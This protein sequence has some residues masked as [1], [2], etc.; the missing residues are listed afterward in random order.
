MEAFGAAAWSLS[1]LEWPS[2]ICD[3]TSSTSM[4]CWVSA[5]SIK[6]GVPKEGID[7]TVDRVSQSR[8]H[9]AL[10]DTIFA[11]ARTFKRF[12]MVFFVISVS[13]GRS[14]LEQSH[15]PTTYPWSLRYNY[16]NRLGCSDVLQWRTGGGR[17]RD[18][19]KSELWP[20]W[21]F[22]VTARGMG[23]LLLG[24]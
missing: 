9:Q 12:F 22:E 11:H 19:M 5:R 17:N 6:H 2:D 8:F 16:N 3:S 4:M 23:I 24:M 13:P 14:R 20:S 10:D 18:R 7:G 1:V 21:P 15:F